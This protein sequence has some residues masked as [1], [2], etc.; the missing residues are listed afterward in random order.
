MALR[1]AVALQLQNRHQRLGRPGHW[2]Q[3]TPELRTQAQR[4]LRNVLFDRNGRAVRDPSPEKILPKLSLG[5]WRY[6]FTRHYEGSLWTTIA[7][8]FS[9]SAEVSRHDLERRM[10]RIST[11]RNRIAHH[12]PLW[13]RDEISR[14]H[15]DLCHMADTLSPDLRRFVDTCSTY[16]DVMA[17]QPVPTKG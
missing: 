9:P 8:A 10:E 15:H 1:T 16:D 7:R 3:D 13:Y 4:T 12:E 2:Y 14:V 6:L 17:R 5:F 11:V